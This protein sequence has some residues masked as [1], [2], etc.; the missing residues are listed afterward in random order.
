MWRSF[1]LRV[2]HYAFA[3]VL[4]LLIP[5]QDTRPGSAQAAYDHAWILFQH[6]DLARSQQ[7]AEQGARQFQ[8]ADPAWASKFQLLEAE[9]MLFRGMY[10]DA[11]RL[12]ASYHS[13]PNNPEGTIRKL[14]IE[15]V[16]LTRQ[17][18]L[19]AA[20][21]RLAQAEGFCKSA[22]YATCGDVFRARGILAS[23][24][25]QLAEA[26]QFFLESFSFARSPS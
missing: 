3:L 21:Q 25:G 15:A 23:K 24:Q 4:L 6:G 9:S 17:Q 7:E 5:L 22:D 20:N 16:A 14:A 11:L 10:D 18:Q 26:R 13:A 12:L 8:T 1:R 19:S 2:F